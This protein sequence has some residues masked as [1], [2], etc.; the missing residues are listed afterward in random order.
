MRAYSPKEIARLQIP[1][2][3]LEGEWRAAFGRPSRYERWFIDGE[4]TSGKST[5]VMLLAKE[6]CKFGKVDYISLEEGANLSFKRRTI[7]L[8]MDEVAGRFK[9]VTNITMEELA[10]R[11]AKPKSANFVFIDSVQYTGMTFPKIKAL[12]LDRFPRKSFIFVSQNYKGRPKGKPANDL[13]FDAGVK[14]STIGFRAYCHGRYVDGA[15]AYF[16]IWEEGAYKY[17]LNK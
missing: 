5:F 4:S 1:E 8:Q 9:A 2:L 3:P 6:L 11:L 15:G 13:K 17:Y 14:I 12:L 7:R 16:T 10:E